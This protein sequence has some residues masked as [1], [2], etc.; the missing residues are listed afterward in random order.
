MD[1]ACAFAS[2]DDD[3]TFSFSGNIESAIME[4]R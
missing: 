4:V 3:W 1:L 2:Q